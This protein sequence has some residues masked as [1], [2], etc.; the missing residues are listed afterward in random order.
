M[1]RM[2]STKVGAWSI[3]HLVRPI[4]RWLLRRSKGKRSVFGGLTPMLL[5]ENIGARSGTMRETPLQYIPDDDRMVL[6]ASNFGNPQHP[7][8]YH[9]LRSHPEV[10]VLADGKRCAVV[11]RE[12]EGQERA[13]ALYTGYD[14][15]QARTGGRQIPVIVLEVRGKSI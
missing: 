15:Y 8:W 2:A 10:H 14:T 6:I 13:C 9:N 3:R 11:A 4:D 5:L 1:E 7:A 12:A